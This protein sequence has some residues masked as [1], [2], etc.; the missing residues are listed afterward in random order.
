MMLLLLANFEYVAHLTQ[1]LPTFIL[2]ALR[3]GHELPE[4]KKQREFK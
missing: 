1:I 2:C 3:N 4:L